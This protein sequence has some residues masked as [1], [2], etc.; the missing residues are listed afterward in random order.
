MLLPPYI[1]AAALVITMTVYETKRSE[2]AQSGSQLTV[3]VKVESSCE[4]RGLCGMADVHELNEPGHVSGGIPATSG[5]PVSVAQLPATADA[6]AGNRID[7][8]E[9]SEPGHV[10]AALPTAPTVSVAAADKPPRERLA[11]R[12]RQVEVD[13]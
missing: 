4:A 2:A 12:D 8:H 11:V 13:F 6:A 1:I 5:A 9:L 3:S 7:V 10:P